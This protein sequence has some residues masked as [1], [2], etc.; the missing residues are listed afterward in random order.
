MQVT[1]TF[2]SL[3]SQKATVIYSEVGMILI[4]TSHLAVGLKKKKSCTL[5]TG[6][7]LKV[8]SAPCNTMKNSPQIRTLYKLVNNEQ[9]LQKRYGKKKSL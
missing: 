4:F 1:G 2:A 6:I 8:T 5:F 7:H 9:L 3:T